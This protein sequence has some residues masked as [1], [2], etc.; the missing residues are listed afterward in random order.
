MC[1]QRRQAA[2]NEA[3]SV[4]T[5]ADDIRNSRRLQKAREAQQ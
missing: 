1:R 5:T 3:Q 4:A 2:D